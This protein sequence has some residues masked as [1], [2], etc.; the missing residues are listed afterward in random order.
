MG[1]RSEKNSSI[2]G[3]V[4]ESTLKGNFPGIVYKS[5]DI[6]G[7]QDLIT[8]IQVKKTKSLAS[9]SIVP[10]MRDDNQNMD[11]FIQGIEKFI[12]TMNGKIYTMLCLASPLNRQDMEKRK[13][14]YE[15]L[16]SALTPHAKLSVAYGEN[17]SL[18]VN[19]S[20]STSFSKSVN[21]SISN[22]N[23]RVVYDKGI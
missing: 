22:S 23:T 9:V 19:K 7:I 3:D 14:G 8:D 2:A 13:H 17:E 11:T 6:D 10:S 18:A 16:C 12:D 21:R 4:L 15:E 1:I 5:K 20:I